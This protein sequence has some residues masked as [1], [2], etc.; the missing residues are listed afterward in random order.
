MST[1]IEAEAKLA[2]LGP[3]PFPLPLGPMAPVVEGGFTGMN[4]SDWIVAGMRERVGAVLRGCPPER[5]VDGRAGAKPYKLAPASEA[6]GTRALHAVGLAKASGSPVLCFLGLASAA[7]GDFHE[8]LNAA[9]L[10]EAPVI[11]LVT[12]HT[13]TDDAPVGAQLATTPEK[14]AQAFGIPT[15]VVKAEAKAVQKAV[16]A[17]RKKG[18]AAL[19]TATVE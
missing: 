19:I 4:K 2:E 6:P 17:A 5:L 12:V 7:S 18:V 15:T 3:T 16:K 1:L 8:A 10:T 9:V 11:F 13:L 14:L